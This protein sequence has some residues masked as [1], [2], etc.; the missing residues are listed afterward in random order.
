MG[1]RLKCI[2]TYSTDPYRNLAFEEYMLDNIEEGECL[3]YLWQNRRTVVIGKNQNAFKEC[4]VSE[5][6][7]DGG[8][9]ARRPSGGGAV[10]HDNGNLNFTFITT[11]R[12]YDVDKQ[13]SVIVE[14]VNSF[15][16]RAEKTGRNDIC[17]DERKF[18]GNA[19]LIKGNKR[20]HHGTILV[21]VDMS[22]LSRYLNVDAKKLR[23][24]GVDSVKSRVINLK[25][26]N[27]EVT[28]DGMRRALA[29]AF[30]KVYGGKSEEIKED[31][32]DNAD[33][34]ALKEK[35][36]SEEWK[37][38]KHIKADLEL[39]DKFPWGD[40][41]MQL[42]IRG[43]AIEDIRVFTDS[44]DTDVAAKIEAA[45]LGERLAKDNLISKLHSCGLGQVAR[46]LSRLITESEI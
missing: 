25:A 39:G 12:N 33:V 26:L 37:F 43:R 16:I 5:L 8:F 36:A 29:A 40:I 10:Y 44:M 46:D 19:F 28:I 11:E 38:G 45:L 21:D 2:N 9:L 13:L 1:L 7:A 31:L 4:K 17:V 30:D 42:A 41:S 3:L 23:S 14:A 24:K 27:D 20:Y 18:S 35:Y 32:I 15:G 22:Q 6:E 34:D